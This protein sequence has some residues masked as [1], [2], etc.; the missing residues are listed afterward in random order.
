MLGQ[1]TKSEQAE[2][3]DEVLEKMDEIVDLLRPV[4]EMDEG[5]RRTVMAAFEGKRGGWLGKFERDYIEEKLDAVLSGED[6]E[7]E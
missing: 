5:F 2:L 3:L 4:A 6:E 1:L 7:E